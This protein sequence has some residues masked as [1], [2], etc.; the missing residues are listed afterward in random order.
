[1]G[2]AKVKVTGPAKAGNFVIPSGEND[3]NGVARSLEDLSY[4]EFRSAVGCVLRD[5]AETA[6][7]TIAVIVMDAEPDP[8]VARMA[9]ELADTQG[10][11]ETMAARNAAM[12]ERLSA[13]ETQIP[14]RAE[15]SQ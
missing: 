15:N 12:V 2:Q 7:R 6:A 13:I 3:G 10:L 14:A 8:G 5:S 1:M 11:I 9:R 4:M